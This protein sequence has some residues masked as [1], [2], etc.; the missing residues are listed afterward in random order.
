MEGPEEV[1]A[2]PVAAGVE[3]LLANTE[4][5]G[6]LVAEDGGGQTAGLP[7]HFVTALPP[8]APQTLGPAQSIT[9]TSGGLRRRFEPRFDA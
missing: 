7:V 4:Y 6:C 2:R 9:A 3:G 5:T 8:E 1:E